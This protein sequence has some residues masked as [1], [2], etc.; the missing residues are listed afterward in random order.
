MSL[1]VSAFQTADR[2]V[3]TPAPRP[4]PPAGSATTQEVAPRC[5]N[6]GDVDTGR[7]WP[8]W[9]RPSRPSRARRPCPPRAPNAMIEA[10]RGPFATAQQSVPPGNGFNGGEVYYP[11]DTSPTGDQERVRPARR[12][13]PRVLPDPQ[14][15]H[16]DAGHPLAEDLRRRRQPARAVPVSEAAR[17]GQD[18]PLPSEVPLHLSAG[19]RP[20]R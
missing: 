14:Q 20:T 13:R 3:A 8:C 7:P 5:D 11:T 6:T 18:L 15:R 2:P 16:D 19:L 17:S 12:G 4:E 9:P 10:S 1:L